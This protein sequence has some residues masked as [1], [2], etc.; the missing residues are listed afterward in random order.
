VS[1]D[2]AVQAQTP[3][4]ASDY[5][6][7]PALSASGMRDL[8]VSPLRYWFLHLNPDKPLREETPAMRFGSALHCAVLEPQKFDRAYA[9]ALI[10]PADCLDTMEDLRGWLKD[11]G[12]A[13]KGT[14]K[15]DVIAQV[16]GVSDS[17]PILEVL[18]QR[19]A[20]EH[21]GKTILS[22]DEWGRVLGAR[23]ALAAEPSF[24]KLMIEGRAEVPYF[25]KDPETSV[26]LKARMDWVA[27]GFT[28]DLKTFSQQRGK[29]IDR[30]VAD[31]IWY[32][33]YYRTGNFYRTVRRLHDGDA[34]MKPF[35]LAF[36]ESE[37]PHEVR[38]KSLIPSL[39]GQVHLYWERGRVE[40]RAFINQYAECLARFGDKPWR[41]EQEVD[42]LVDEDLP[43]QA[44]A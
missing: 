4:E 31:A 38:I 35:I 33:F 22:V 36:V 19:H 30:T 17:V 26:M 5:F 43:Q 14:R 39:D 10:P 1:N 32:E 23:N 8:A 13:P 40:C 27:P 29:S 20:T 42:S 28:M 9:C 6:A 15:A 18:K 7:V 41:T 11:Q 34:A 44:W 21:D 3:I 37:P 24:Q 2:L 25:V 16:Q 12:V